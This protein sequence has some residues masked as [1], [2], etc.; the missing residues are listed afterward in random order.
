MR[1]DD[2][3][4]AAERASRVLGSGPES[5]SPSTGAPES[6]SSGTMP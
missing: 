6:E 4:E 3:P 5:S 2:E 1:S